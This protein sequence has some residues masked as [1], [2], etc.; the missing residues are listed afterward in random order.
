[1]TDD[2]L[3]KLRETIRHDRDMT[4]FERLER[5]DDEMPYWR[6]PCEK[7]LACSPRSIVS[8]RRSRCFG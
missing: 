6:V 4:L 7:L 2:E 1:M 5:P 8:G 3:E